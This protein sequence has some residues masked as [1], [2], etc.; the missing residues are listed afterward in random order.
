MSTH[1]FTEARR[2]ALRGIVA[3][4]AFTAAFAG[5]AVQ[6]TLGAPADGSGT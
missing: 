3:A 5:P 4:C 2:R 1:R 6:A